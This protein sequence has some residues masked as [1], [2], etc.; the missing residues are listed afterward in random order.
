MSV[1]LT[2]PPCGGGVERS[3]ISDRP[4]SNHACGGWWEEHWA[5]LRHQLAA[6]GGLLLDR[7]PTIETPPGYADLRN[8]EP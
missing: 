3:Y 8:I 5:P 1:R 6:A 4:R 2:L 7:L